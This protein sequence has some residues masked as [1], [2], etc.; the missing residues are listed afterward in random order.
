MNGRD[1]IPAADGDKV[2]GSAADIIDQIAAA[3]ANT[4]GEKVSLGRILDHVGH[5][6]HGPFLLVPALIAFLPTGAIPTMPTIMGLT[7]II[8]AVQVLLAG[9]HVWLPRR[10]ERLS[11]RKTR[12]SSA[13][14][15]ARPWAQR[16][17]AILSPRL[18][19][20]T[21]RF[22]ARIVAVVVI[23]LALLM[24]PL[25]FLPFATAMPSS[26]VVI[27]SIGLTVG[28]GVW[29]LTGL[30]LAAIFLGVGT[31][32]AIGVIF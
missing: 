6:S 21:G 24:P 28:D 5:R 29:V 13:M 14:K 3:A 9:D 31:W 10:L 11:I 2:V 8:V 32:L 1:A 15:K 23:A 26:A 25:E 16:L 22:A 27:L 20:L 19:I 4:E 7:L 18:R 12:V 30:V 17:D